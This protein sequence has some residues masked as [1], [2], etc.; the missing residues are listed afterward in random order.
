M[1]SSEKN[2]SQETQLS[3]YFDPERLGLQVVLEDI[4]LDPY[5]NILGVGGRVRSIFHQ[6]IRLGEKVEFRPLGFQ[7]DFVSLGWSLCRL[8]WITPWS[9]VCN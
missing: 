9:K 4:F 3:F 7:Q 6:Y 8:R 5:L 2:I 1:S